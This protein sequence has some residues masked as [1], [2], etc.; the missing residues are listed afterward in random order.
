MGAL[1]LLSVTATAHDCAQFVGLVPVTLAVPAH[2]QVITPQW[3]CCNG[4]VAG[5]PAAVAAPANTATNTAPA[6]MVLQCKPE[7]PQGIIG[8]L[9]SGTGRWIVRGGKAVSGIGRGIF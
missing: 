5:Q 2:V 4:Q 6:V 7:E 8:G 3:G 9:V 1:A